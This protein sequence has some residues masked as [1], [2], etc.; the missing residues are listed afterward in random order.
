MP[1]AAS[2][3]N[4]SIG[5]PQQCFLLLSATYTKIPIF[6]YTAKYLF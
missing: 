2:G 4:L 6:Y 3:I 1:I 5:T